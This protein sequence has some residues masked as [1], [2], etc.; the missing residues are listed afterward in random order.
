MGETEVR[1]MDRV[2][3]GQVQAEE[4]Y[5]CEECHCDNSGKVMPQEW[6]IFNRGTDLEFAECSW[7]EHEVNPDVTLRD[8][9]PDVCPKCGCRME[10]QVTVEEVDAR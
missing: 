6:R 2:E 1:P 8:W 7:C 5:H 4:E 9:Y 3:H 10:W